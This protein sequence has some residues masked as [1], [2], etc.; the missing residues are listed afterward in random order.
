V[1]KPKGGGNLEKRKAYKMRLEPEETAWVE[2]GI[3]N[4]NFYW[5]H[6]AGVKGEK[7]RG[8]KMGLDEGR[9]WIFP[10]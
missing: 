2:K 6:E 10:C 5:E 7:G 1:G 9:N 4:L 8:G 3:G